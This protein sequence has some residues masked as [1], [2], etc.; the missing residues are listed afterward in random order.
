[1]APQLRRA[2]DLARRVVPGALLLAGVTVALVAAI[3][4]LLGGDPRKALLAILEG[5]IG[6]PTSITE[7]LIKATPLVFTGLSAAVAFR[8][9]VWNIGAEGQFLAGM[10]SAALAGLLL[11]PLPP[12]VAVSLCLVCGAAGGALW[13]GFPAF[14]KLKRDVPEVISTIMLNFLA[15]YLVEYLVRGPIHD[16][17]STSD[18]SPLLPEWTH[19]ERLRAL[20]GLRTVGGGSLTLP[21]GEKVLGLGIEVGRLHLGVLLAFLVVPLVWLWFTRTGT[22]F[23]IRAVG[24]N[25]VASASAGIA[26]AR[27]IGIAF[28]SSGALA[29]LGGAVE[30]LGLIQRMYRYAP[31][32]PGYGFSG[33]A[34]A[35]LGQLHPL[36]VLASALFFGGLSAGCSQ[37]Q[38]S[39][40]IS[41]HVAYVIQAAVVLLL[42][43]APAIKRKRAGKS[44]L[45][46]SPEPTSG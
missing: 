22:G 35:L 11:P 26:T 42:I 23:R 31:G 28:L 38:R 15:V 5:S 46:V 4:A 24:L 2:L 40:G 18:W 8:C 34:V 9:G 25:P 16:P 39:A 19:L 17:T 32:E 29:G 33:I 7:T 6:S 30:I 41:F 14:L 3:V 43:S 27:T 21:G 44:G 20:T 10:L 1:M 36:G 13:A 12:P 45:P 37:M